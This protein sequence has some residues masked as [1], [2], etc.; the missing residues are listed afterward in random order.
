M[1]KLI[2]ILICSVGFFSCI[3][4]E[5]CKIC[6]TIITVKVKGADPVITKI[7]NYA[8]GNELEEMKTGKYNYYEVNHDRVGYAEKDIKTTCE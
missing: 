3:K 2:F 5:E 1:K 4:K 6:T 8:C 7:T